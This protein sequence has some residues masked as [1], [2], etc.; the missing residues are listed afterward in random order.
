MG[1]RRSVM[2][3]K[4]NPLGAGGRSSTLGS[5]SGTFGAG[6]LGA[7]LAASGAALLRAAKGSACE[8]AEVCKAPQPRSNGRS[9][10]DHSR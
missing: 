6:T 5:P 2:T 7:T 3:W 4:S 10:G 9:N 1:L 8:R